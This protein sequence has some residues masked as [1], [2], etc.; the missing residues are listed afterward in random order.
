MALSAAWASVT[1]MSP[2][3]TSQW[4]ENDEPRK[5]ERVSF[6][7]EDIGWNRKPFATEAFRDV[8]RSVNSILT[9]PSYESG[10]SLTNEL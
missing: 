10:V 7:I 1:G 9:L 3:G 5:G 2:P 6:F 4:V 8:V